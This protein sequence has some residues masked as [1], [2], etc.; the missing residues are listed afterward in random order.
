[1]NLSDLIK[2]KNIRKMQIDKGQIKNILEISERDIEVAE[3]LLD[4]SFDASFIYI[5]QEN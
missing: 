2:N 5:C 3:K 1:M 4:I